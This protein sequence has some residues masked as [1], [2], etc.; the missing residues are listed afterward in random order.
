MSTLTSP[1]SLFSL[2]E[3]LVC[4]NLNTTSNG[5]MM[6]TALLSKLLTTSPIEIDIGLNILH[7]DRFVL[8]NPGQSLETITVTRPCVL[9]IR[10]YL[11]IIPSLPMLSLTCCPHLET[12]YVTGLHLSDIKNILSFHQMFVFRNDVFYT[13]VKERIKKFQKEHTL[14]RGPDQLDPL[15]EAA[16][17]MRG[18]GVV[19]LKPK[20]VSSFKQKIISSRSNNTTVMGNTVDLHNDSLFDE[21]YSILCSSPL[22]ELPVFAPLYM[23]H[24]SGSELNSKVKNL[25]VKLNTFQVR[26]IKQN[27]A[28]AQSKKRIV[29][30][31]KECLRSLKNRKSRLLILA[32]DLENTLND[33]KPVEHRVDELC[34]MASETNT[35]FL[36]CLT[37]YA[38]C[39]ALGRSGGFVSCV[40]VVFDNGVEHDIRDIIDLVEE[41]RIKAD[42]RAL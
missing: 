37:R 30:G 31:F 4:C 18:P 1:Q 32:V 5:S 27:K 19:K 2:D 26:K 41:Y 15:A 6:F 23:P 22:M 42:L 7:D 8:Y 21:D 33:E 36:F 3:A 24:I 13:L 20:K 10:H 28:S 38:L 25:L 11:S 9:M 39:K 40:S 29:L 16:K 34:K 35:P 12:F 17:K 14:P